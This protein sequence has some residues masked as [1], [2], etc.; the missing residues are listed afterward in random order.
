MSDEY[1]SLA[2]LAASSRQ[3][4][5]DLMGIV[6]I[7]VA[8][9]L[10]S[11]NECR[12]VRQSSGDCDALLLTTAQFRRP[13]IAS[14]AE[15]DG[16][17]ELH[18][19]AAIQSALREHWHKYVFERRKLG[20]QVV[21]LE[22][23][24]DPLITVARASRAGKTGDLQFTHD[25][26]TAIWTV[27]CGDEVEQRGLAGPGWTDEERQLALRHLERD[28]LK[29]SNLPV[30]CAHK[31]SLPIE[32]RQKMLSRSLLRQRARDGAF[33]QPPCS[34]GYA[35]CDGTQRY[36]DYHCGNKQVK[37]G[38]DRAQF[39]HQRRHGEMAW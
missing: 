18:C 35:K 34:R 1:Q 4:L 28:I 12:V 37:T 14:I 17:E 10:V 19:A 30:S 29:R 7:E 5:G 22:D 16:V 38:L 39:G 21:R 20:K 36:A 2:P 24:P 6:V 27:H 33:M 9:W 25:D 8:S 13:V 31:S 15:A 23:E 11:E 26:F 32:R 3:Q